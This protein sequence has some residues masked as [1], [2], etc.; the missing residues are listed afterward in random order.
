MLK[1]ITLL[2]ISSMTV[3]AGATLSPALPQIQ[4]FFQEVPDSGFWV[5]LMLTM[6]GLFT[7]ISA[8][9]AGIIADR[10]GRRP[11]LLAAILLYG[12]AGGS[13]LV[14]SSISGLLIGRALLGLAVGAI[15]TTA[16]ALIADYY[17]GPQRNQVMGIQA[18]FMSFG[19]VAFLVLGGLLADIG[20][21]APFLIYLMAFV[22][23]GLAL[24]FITEPK[25]ETPSPQDAVV[26]APP[27]PLPTAGL[28]AIYALV[29]VTMT[30]FYLVPVQLPF[31]LQTLS[32]GQVS[33]TSIGM[34]IG[35]QNLAS[36]LVST[37]YRA[38]KDRLSFPA[39]MG[40]GF[41]GMAL[42][43]GVIAMA[44]S[45]S[46]VLV[47]L[48]TAGSGLGLLIPNVNVWVNAIAPPTSRG[49]A[50]GGLTTCLFLGQFASPILSQPL[51]GPLGLAYTYGLVGLG[52][53][54]LAGVMLAV[55]SRQRPQ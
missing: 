25:V 8:P 5:R 50:I 16:T 3:M 18:S 11:L 4:K 26:A 28:A 29:F 44:S 34:A 1:L 15:M 52:L 21:R 55:A 23:F 43:Y 22:V 49:R 27:A 6:P 30:A 51:I 12:L 37:R 35:A 41:V 9:F 2:L 32:E 19:G 45:Y 7:A 39:V 20:W 53:A 14:L 13:G 47:G 36:A 48:V 24:V 42:G 38:V 46:L 40:I 17:Q 31:Y 10:L 33:N 54:V